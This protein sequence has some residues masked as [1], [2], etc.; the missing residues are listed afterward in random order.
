MHTGLFIINE[1]AKIGK[2]CQLYPQ[3]LVGQ[4]DKGKSPVIG[5]NVVICSGAKI[6]G[7]VEIG[8]NCIIAANALIVKSVPGNSLMVYQL[9]IKKK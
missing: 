1:Y 2:N 5:D 8:N 9:A 6:V 4:T 3:I 7:P